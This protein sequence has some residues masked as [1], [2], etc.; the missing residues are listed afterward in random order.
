MLRDP[1]FHVQVL[2][3]LST[4]LL[5]NLEQ[6]FEEEEVKLLASL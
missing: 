3:N 1:S 6:S 5:L 2:N 4:A